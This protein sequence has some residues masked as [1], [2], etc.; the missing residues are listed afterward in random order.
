M[1]RHPHHYVP[2][3]MHVHTCTHRTADARAPR[4]VTNVR[5][6]EESREEKGLNVSNDWSGGMTELL[7]ALGGALGGVM[8]EDKATMEFLAV[9]LAPFF[10]LLAHLEQQCLG[11]YM[12]GRQRIYDNRCIHQTTHYICPVVEYTLYN[13]TVCV[14]SFLLTECTR[15]VKRAH[16]T[17]ENAYQIFVRTDYSSKWVDYFCPAPEVFDSAQCS[18]I[19]SFT[20][21]TTP[22]PPTSTPSSTQ[23]PHKS[24]WFS[25]SKLLKQHPT[26]EPGEAHTVVVKR[27]P[28]DNHEVSRPPST[29]SPK[30]SDN[31]V[32][33][34]AK[35]CE[36]HR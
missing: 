17:Q 7:G 32:Q 12:T 30:T 14:L 26:Q 23:P 5:S 10:V 31:E 24:Q 6:M 25:D 27:L 19:L 28:V 15:G 34:P 9:Y 4:F 18:C 22:T 2:T 1:C 36:T 13:F 20:R 11:Q 29:S 8:M 33:P 3:Q 35:R 16:P 21:A